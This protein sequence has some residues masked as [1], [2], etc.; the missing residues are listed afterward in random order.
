MGWNTVLIISSGFTI[1]IKIQKIKY[2]RVK[3]R[4]TLTS[5]VF[6]YQEEGIKDCKIKGKD[7][8]INWISDL[9]RYK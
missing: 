8:L 7:N 9:S 5:Q 2:D 6:M 3:K 4:L 1:P